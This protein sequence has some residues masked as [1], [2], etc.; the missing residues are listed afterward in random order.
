MCECDLP[1]DRLHL[2]AR[3]AAGATADGHSCT[4]E[5]R[6][7]EE[8]QR[9]QAGARG[10]MGDPR[11]RAREDEQQPF[12]STA[13]VASCNSVRSCES[14]DIRSPTLARP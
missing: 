9:A 7:D 10:T 3:A 5:E 13:V 14:R 12:D 4:A 11:Q 2:V 1:V 8:D 6:D